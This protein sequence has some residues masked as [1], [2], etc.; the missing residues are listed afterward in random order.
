MKSRPER[1]GARFGDFGYAAPSPQQ[2]CDAGS[3][4]I[5]REHRAFFAHQSV[6][7]CLQKEEVVVDR[8]SRELVSPVAW[9]GS[10]IP[11]E[12][13]GKTR[14]LLPTAGA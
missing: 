1:R 12:D 4:A 13:T 3:P 6:D 9:L 10:L 14:V 11:R 7:E 5:R 2:H 8:V